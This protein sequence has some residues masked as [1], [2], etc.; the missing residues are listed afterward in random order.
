MIRIGLGY[1]SHRLDPGRPLVVGG[2]RVPWEKGLAG[3]SDADVL[4]HAVI[5]ALLGASGRGNIGE[6]FPDTDPA[7]CGADS[8]ELL[9]G[10]WRELSGAGYEIGNLDCVIQAEEPRL[11]PYLPEMRRRLSETLGA[12][13]SSV[14]VKP[15]TAEGMGAVGRGEG[16]AAL[17]VVLLHNPTSADIS[18]GRLDPTDD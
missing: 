2:V 16:M 11:A 14:N 6:R 10:V 15:K 8:L 18:S 1:D 3:H 17:A 9:A 4:V 12:P 7:H 13:L 5:D